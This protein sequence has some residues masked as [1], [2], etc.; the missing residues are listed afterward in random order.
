MFIYDKLELRTNVKECYEHN[1]KIYVILEETVFY[2]ASGGQCCDIGLINDIAVVDVFKYNDEIIHQVEDV[3]AGE[4]YCIVNEKVRWMNSLLHSAQHL[5]SAVFENNGYDTTS[6]SMK[7][8][9]FTI[10]VTTKVT[11][12]ILDD[13][14]LQINLLIR[15]GRNIYSRLYSDAIDTDIDTENLSFDLSSMRIVVIESLEK[16]ICGGTHINNIKEIEF[17]KIIKFKY[18]GSK[19]KLEVMI[20]RDAIL[21]V[22]E[23][24]NKY[25]DIIKLVNQNNEN[26]YD[27][28]ENKLKDNKKMCK[29]LSK[30]EKGLL[31]EN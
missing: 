20:G 17:L 2:P 21:Y 26:V 27:Y 29:K 4:V 8:N 18:V 7:D 31:D 12:D 6:F 5:L 9:Y 3:I 1:S 15:E 28:I 14:E 24:F 16:N 23:Y 11:R 25:T 22:N 30:L 19:T 10:D 13:M